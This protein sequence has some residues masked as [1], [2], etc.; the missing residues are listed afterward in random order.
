[1]VML[2]SAFLGL[3]LFHLPPHSSVTPIDYARI[4]RAIEER[5]F[6]WA[7]QELEKYL[8]TNPQDF[9]A[10]MLLGVVYD[11]ENQPG[12]A[13]REFQKS[14]ELRPREPAPHINLGKSY[15]RRGDPLA[16]ARELRLALKLDPHS[17]T[18]FENLGLVLMGQGEYAQAL[19]AFQKA[20]DL[21]PKDLSFWLNVF[22]A[23]LALKKFPEVRASAKRIIELASPS[24]DLYN[25]LGAM[26]A[27]S[28]DYTGAI[29]NL[30]KARA[31]DPHLERAQYNLGLAYYRAKNLTRALQTLELLAQKR[32][33]AEAENLLG[34]VYE[35][36]R[37]YLKA[38]RAFQKAAEM[39]SANED[40]RFDFVRELLAHHNFDV[41][42]LVAAPAVHDFPQSQRLRL[43]LGVAYFGRGRFRESLESFLETAKKIP[44]AELPLYFL[45]LAADATGKNLEETRALLEA[46]LKR[47]P[48][49]FWPYYFLGRAAYRPDF[50][51]E[52]T[53]DLGRA[54]RLLKE[55]IRLNPNYAD[56]HYEL[57]VVYSEQEHW[58]QAME[59]YEKAIRLKP[60]LSEAHYRLSQSYRHIGDLRRS[61]Q[62]MQIHRKLKQQEAQETLR[63]RQV[64]AFL[65]KL[66]Q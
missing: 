37:E 40:Y 47:H 3:A 60:D 46:Y 58:P 30:E 57:G 45:A 53:G 62:E 26:Q 18:A 34:E 9:R 19:T 13:A 12:E 51:G 61:E 59:E 49:Q 54:E 33:T 23:Q 52:Q 36:S 14:V 55:S 50:R 63:L 56:S 27:E 42:T 16:A 35:E 48:E 39:E 17:A 7:Y 66:R 32:D 8:R 24:A 29:E 64:N 6:A 10:H 1:M 21:D 22:K 2:T 15:A 44:D 25:R 11:E 31:L 43:A 38:V 20:I 65:Y 41:A 4:E 5:D 28:G